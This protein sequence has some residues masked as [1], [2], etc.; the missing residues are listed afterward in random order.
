MKILCLNTA[1]SFTSIALIEK[2]KTDNKLL[3][4]D[5]WPSQ[6]DEAEKIMPKIPK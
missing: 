6:N 4:E 3:A 1:T 2:Q 5:T